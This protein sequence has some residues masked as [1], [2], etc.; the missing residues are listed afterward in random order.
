MLTI[1]V[2]IVTYGPEGLK[3]VKQMLPSEREGVKYVVSWQFPGEKIIPEDL[4]KRKDVIVRFL[5]VPGVANNRNNAIDYCTGDII[6]IADDDI[7]YVDDFD[8]IVR[9]AF[10]NNPTVDVGIFKV[11]LAKE[12]IYPAEDC[13][14]GVP[15]PKHYYVN[16]MELALRRKS[17]ADLR[18]W[19]E[20]GIGASCLKACEEE[21]LL[22]SAIKRGLNCRFF[23]RT[24]CSHPT[25]S[26][27]DRAEPGIMKAMGFI[28]YTLYPFSFSVRVPLKAYRLSKSGKTTFLKS[29]LPM[30]SGILFAMKNLKRI[31]RQYRW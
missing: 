24:I 19:P 22:I 5:E 6:M 27:G 26:T 16:N 7:I 1:D 23:N 9:E 25:P 31:P 2:A 3:R 4:K 18:Y 21:F 15:F 29:L 8:S 10:E 14:I 13:R 30:I 11:K 28:I 20:L 17:L 12:K